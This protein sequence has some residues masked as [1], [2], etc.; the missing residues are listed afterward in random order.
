VAIWVLA[1]VTALLKITFSGSQL[2]TVSLVS[3]PKIVRININGLPY[4]NAQYLETPLSLEVKPG[5]IKLKIMREGYQNYVT[6]L[7]KSEGEN[8]TL[9]EVR[10]IPKEGTQFASIEVTGDR[11]S[12]PYYVEINRGLF[13][14]ETPMVADNF[15]RNGK[16]ILEV[17]PQGPGTKPRTRC[18]FALGEQSSKGSPGADKIKIRISMQPDGTYHF[19]GCQEK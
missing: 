19:T 17:F 3:D 10:L 18:T 4:Q 15:P 13:R 14:G 12:K 7:E 8:V 1:V 16:H 5:K 2:V 9:S 11:I 6:N